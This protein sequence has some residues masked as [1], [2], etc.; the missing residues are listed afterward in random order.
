M[1]WYSLGFFTGSDVYQAWISGTGL[2]HH[3]KLTKTFGDQ[4]E[5]MTRDPKC[6]SCSTCFSTKKSRRPENSLP[7]KMSWDCKNALSYRDT[8]VFEL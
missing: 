3:Q 8:Y 1:G 6:E 4:C 2:G 7:W 5:S